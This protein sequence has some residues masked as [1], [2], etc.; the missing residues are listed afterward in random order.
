MK[1]PIFSSIDALLERG[2]ALVEE[3]EKTLGNSVALDDRVTSFFFDGLD[4]TKYLRAL[5][6]GFDFTQPCDEWPDPWDHRRD[7]DQFCEET[8]FFVL[9]VDLSE[10]GIDPTPLVEMSWV[11]ANHRELFPKPQHPRV[12]DAELL[13]AAE[14][15]NRTQQRALSVLTRLQRVLCFR[16][17]EIGALRAKLDENRDRD[18]WLY[19]RALG[20]ATNAM[21]RH[22]LSQRPEWDQISTEQGISQAILRYCGRHGKARPQ[23]R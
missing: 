20:G 12:P 18:E 3:V 10:T 16:R 22:E 14:E 2:Q 6:N 17:G 21:I 23:R 5:A 11:V 19:R 4:I 15:I 8:D 9:V 13:A 1:E 7:A